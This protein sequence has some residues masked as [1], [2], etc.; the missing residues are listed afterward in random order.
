MLPANQTPS[1]CLFLPSTSEASWWGCG[2]QGMKVLPL[3]TNFCTG[4]SP[5]GWAPVL[6][7]R[8]RPQCASQQGEATVLYFSSLLAG[9]MA[10]NEKCLCWPYFSTTG[11]T[12]GKQY[13]AY[14]GNSKH[15]FFS[16]FLKSTVFSISWRDLLFLSAFCALQTIIWIDSFCTGPQRVGISDHKK[17]LKQKSTCLTF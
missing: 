3:T 6:R 5:L 15:L 16:S 13:L 7:H 4:Q 2:Q 14:Q 1:A 9:K 8:L 12:L 17:A 10:W 11:G